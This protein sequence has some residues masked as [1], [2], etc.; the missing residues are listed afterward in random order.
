MACSG[1]EEGLRVLCVA[2]DPA[3]GT[4]ADEGGGVS[5]A[6]DPEVWLGGHDESRHAGQRTRR[7]PEDRRAVVPPQRRFDSLS[8]KIIS[9][10]IN[11][12]LT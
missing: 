6:G 11:S 8:I 4:V 9:S 10:I 7:N 12:H 5:R 3:V 1:R 2:R